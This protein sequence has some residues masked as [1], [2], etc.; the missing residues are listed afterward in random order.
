MRTD[1]VLEAAA[2]AVMKQLAANPTLAIPVDKDVAE[3]MGFSEEKAVFTED[4]DEDALLT[5]G[6]GGAVYHGEK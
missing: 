2:Q 3:Y 5:F 1:K 4:F 6:P